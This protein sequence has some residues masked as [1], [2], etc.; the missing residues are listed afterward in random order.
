MSYWPLCSKDKELGTY[1]PAFRLFVLANKF[2]KEA[3]N[4][5]R[6]TRVSKALFQVKKKQKKLAINLLSYVSDL[7]IWVWK[8][9]KKL[10]GFHFWHFTSVRKQW[11]REAA[12]TLWPIQILAFLHDRTDSFQLSSTDRLSYGRSPPNKFFNTDF[13]ELSRPWEDGWI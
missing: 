4:P 3:Q 5:R 7:L 2:T 10:C 12:F 9:L 13:F 1:W 11:F 6:D 8:L